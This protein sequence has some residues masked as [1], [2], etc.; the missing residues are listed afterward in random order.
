MIAVLKLGFHECV[1]VGIQIQ[2]TDNTSLLH[3]TMYTLAYIC[4]FIH[5]SASILF[6]CF[7]IPIAQRHSLL[8]NKL[9][10][11]QRRR[12]KV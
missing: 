6:L 11:W 2:N 7:M 4:I 12:F 8:E 9:K 3:I 1:N 10:F 5:I